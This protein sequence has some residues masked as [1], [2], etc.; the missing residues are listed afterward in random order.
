MLSRPPST[1]SAPD[2]PTPEAAAPPLLLADVDV[3]ARGRWV[4]ALTQAGF[5]VVTAGTASAVLE[6]AFVRPPAAVLICDRLPDVGGEE[7]CRALKDRPEFARIPILRIG[8]EPPGPDRSSADGWIG[9]NASEEELVSYAR[10]FLRLSR[11]EQRCVEMESQQQTADGTRAS[12][13][14]HGGCSDASGSVRD[15][16]RAGVAATRNPG[17]CIDAVE[18]GLAQA[19]SCPFRCLA[20]Q[21]PVPL[22][23]AID[24]RIVYL[25]PGYR[26]LL[27]ARTNEQ[28]LGRSLLEFVHPDDRAGVSERLRFAL[29][30]GRTADRLDGQLIRLDGSAVAVEAAASAWETAR[31]RGLVLTARDVTRRKRIEQSLRLRESELRLIMD[32]APA[33]ISYV[34]TECRYRRV[35]KA[36]QRQFGVAPEILQGRHL[37]EVLGDAAWKVIE[38]YVR[39][40]LQG[41]PVSFEQKI[42]Y[43]Q[44]GSRWMCANYTPDRDEAGIVRGFVA[45]VL[46]VSGRKAAEA[47]LLESEHR[48]RQIAETISHVFWMTE[49]H[50]ERVLYVSPAFRHIW[51]RPPEELYAR[52]RLWLEPI[53]PE[54]RD[55]VQSAFEHWIDD[56]GTGEYDFEFRIIRPD[57]ALRWISD[58]GRL[59]RDAAGKVHRATGI[60]EDI[61][62]RKQL[63][64]AL[65]ASE[66]FK[67]GVLDSLPAQIA[68]L[69]VHGVIGAVNEPW[70]RFARDNRCADAAHCHV[71]ANYLEAFRSAIDAGDIYARRALCGVESVLRNEQSRFELEYP[72]NRSHEARWLLMHVLR[73]A[74]EYGGAIVTQLDISSQKRIERALR[75]SQA[76]LKQAQV[77]GQIGSW[78]L[79]VR[80]NQLVWSDEN[81][82]IFGIPCGTPLCYET[83]LG[84][85]HPD[86]REYVDRKWIE[87]LG[88]SPYDIEHRIVVGGGIK[89]V[90]ER[91]ELEFEPD[92]DLRGGFGTTQDITERKR[93][94]REIARLNQDLQRRIHELETIFATVPI[95]LAIAED[96][97]GRRIRGNPTIERL[98]GLPAGPESSM[99]A[100]QPAPLRMFHDRD[101]LPAEELPMQR[102]IRGEC[103]SGQVLDVIRPDG[104][105]VMLFSTSA[106]LFD[107]QGEPRGAVAAFLDITPLK[108]A[109]EALRVS[110]ARFRAMIQAVPAL[111]FEGDAEGNNTFASESWCGFTGLS[112]ADTAGRGWLRAVH[113]DDRPTVAQRWSEAMHSGSL[114]ESKHRIRRA[115]GAYRWFIA[116]ALPIQN[117]AG[118]I[119]RWAGSLTDIHD[120]V[121]SEAAL[122]DREAHIRQLLE[123][124][125]Q[126]VWT[127]EP[128]GRCDYLSPQWL[129]YTGLSEHSQLGRLWIRQIYREDRMRVIRQWREAAT[130][131]VMFEAELR[132]RRA[133]GVYHWFQSRAVPLSDK[134]GN[135]V[136]WLG[137]HSDIEELKQA[138]QALRKADR[139]KDEFLAMLSHE[140]RNPLAPIRSAAAVLRAVGHHDPGLQKARDIIARQVDHMTL[141]IDDL[142]DV[143]RIMHGQVALKRRVLSIAEVVDQGVEA[144]IPAIESRRHRLSVTMP[145]QAVYLEG[146]LVRLVQ[147]VTNLL[148]N[149]AKYTDD[150]GDI[151]LTVAIEECSVVLRIEDSGMGIPADL[152]PGVFDVFTQGPRALDR[153]QGGLGIGLSL[154]RKLVDMHGGTIEARSGG[155]GQGSEFTVR[156]P[157]LAAHPPLPAPRPAVPDPRSVAPAKAM[158]IL[159]V[160]DNR[161][162]AQALALLLSLE[163]HQVREAHEGLDAIESARSFRPQMVMLDIGLPGMDGFEVA[164]RLRRCPEARDAVFIAIT[165]YAEP[166]IL[167]R[168]REAGFRKH[169]VKPVETQDLLDV[170]AECALDDAD[171]LSADPPG[172]VLR[173]TDAAAQ[174][175]L[176]GFQKR[177]DR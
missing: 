104:N 170:L 52:P 110:E 144:S 15:D 36:Y 113:P 89:W 98:L 76:D 163:G 80:R 114:Y 147:V 115:D 57:G 45:Q 40:A 108:R 59:V 101:E 38:P 1:E 10:V 23:V 129:R 55:A 146:D 37:R 94:E 66:Q 8:G 78:R 96:P 122:R 74:A 51:G 68:V 168:S 120:L 81:H 171:R 7:L 58:R 100:A 27:G 30:Q 175:E 41:E 72:C 162:A 50:P 16:V 154:A 60:A 121:Q 42:P 105:T 106:P 97:E 82:R 28:V 26:D 117:G 160:D 148:R 111:T 88:G 65:R 157:R 62:E 102:A 136:K 118:L 138:D 19:L 149:A 46:D 145:P 93:V 174:T 64:Q 14:P 109:E 77:I 103:V 49:L 48:F 176:D 159:V 4:D 44:G 75:D 139:Q 119:E 166:Q 134:E 137:T 39:R 95:G 152:L 63:E 116:R 32:S 107:E 130:R 21:A 24:E 177:N 125:P 17:L 112:A 5:A 3:S 67:Q 6:A 70:R 167:R 132:I 12:P 153:S 92:G 155:I 124:L 86:D 164:E 141:L 54:D 13:L 47:D 90:R 2:H 173:A 35:N 126:L 69:D 61:T 33:L 140:L 169:L 20:D 71:G 91:A 34:D 29:Q 156:L 158:R 150:G 133:D 25:N 127:C 9:E 11:A 22:A 31:G 18:C 83:F 135:I 56:A 73:P 85:V 165:G 43:A 143:S 87:A 142:L 53:H 161:D 84:V 131:G 123:A 151:R 172:V 79:D 128:D 99:T